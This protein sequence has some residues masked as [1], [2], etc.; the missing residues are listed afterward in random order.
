MGGE[1]KITEKEE[2]KERII[3]LL[4]H[5]RSGKKLFDSA[6]KYLSENNL[7][8]PK[9]QEDFDK[10]TGKDNDFWKKILKIIS[11]IYEKELDEKELIELITSNFEQFIKEILKL[12]F[13]YEFQS[14]EEKTIGALDKLLDFLK[15]SKNSLVVEDNDDVKVFYPISEIEKGYTSPFQPGEIK[16]Y[17]II[18]IRINKENKKMY[19]NGIKRNRFLFGKQLIKEDKSIFQQEKIAEFETFEINPSKFFINLR[20]NNFYVKKISINDPYFSLMINAKKDF[21]E[22][23]EFI[24]LELF[25]NDTMDFLKIKT[26]DLVYSGKFNNEVENVPIRIS[27]NFEKQSSGEAIERFFKI[28]L[29]LQTR[30]KNI[31]TAAVTEQI[32]NKL[33]ELGLEINKSFRM[34]ISYYFQRFIGG[35]EEFRERYFEII[36]EI[37]DKNKVVEELKKKEIIFVGNKHISFDRDKFI[38]YL[39]QIFSQLKNIKLEENGKNFEII[40]IKKE[41]SRLDLRLKFYSDE[42]ERKYSYI[43]LIKIPF[44]DR[45]SKYDEI[46]YPILRNVEFYSLIEGILNKKYNDVLRRVYFSVKKYLIHCYNVLLENEAYKSYVYINDYLKEI[47]K[48]TDL[49]KVGRIIEKHANILLKYLFGNYLVYGG[50]NSPDG[51]LYLDNNA[52]FIIDSK[53]HKKIGKGE[54]RKIKEYLEQF[55][56]KED[57]PKTNNGFFILSGE[58]IK[59]TGNGSLNFDAKKEVLKNTDYKVGF[60]TLEFITKLFELS[61]NF[62]NLFKQPELMKDFTEALKKSFEKSL[63]LKTIDKLVKSEEK[64]INQLSNKLETKKA[65]YL[66]QKKAEGL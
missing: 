49:R 5:D 13:D 18:L 55:P 21:F 35:K 30:K 23:D 56:D 45:L 66:P 22:V 38:D 65:E 34:P 25:F 7:T 24:N 16:L 58:L 40:E 1:I 14:E 54:F 8:I 43:Y 41:G 6:N 4:F 12:R 11:S 9:L 15:K 31:D 36:N 32:K 50:K 57:L 60:I 37:D 20:E 27:I 61:R 52:A 19:L 47:K 33:K 28:S 51:Y 46:Y 2:I 29:A 63:E 10:T 42:K 64:I 59:K 3:P 44:G 26:L 53:I 17:P 48:T 62:R 39:K